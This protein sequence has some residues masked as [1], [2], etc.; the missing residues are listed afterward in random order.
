[1]KDKGRKV[2][3]KRKDDGDNGILTPIRNCRWLQVWSAVEMSVSSF[4]YFARL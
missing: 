2:G 3:G 1:M 4:G